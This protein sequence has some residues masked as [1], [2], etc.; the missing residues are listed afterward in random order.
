MATIG[1][2]ELITAPDQDPAEL[3]ALVW[4]GNSRVVYLG[5]KVWNVGTATYYYLVDQTPPDLVA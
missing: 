4:P 2:Y 3:S 1:E 5:C